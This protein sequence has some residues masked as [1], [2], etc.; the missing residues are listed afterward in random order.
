MGTV[1]QW[2][3]WFHSST[4]KKDYRLCNLHFLSICH[5]PSKGRFERITQVYAAAVEAATIGNGE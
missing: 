2:K 5:H 1:I 3:K 4:G